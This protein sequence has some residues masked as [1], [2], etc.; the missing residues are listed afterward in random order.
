MSISNVVEGMAIEGAGDISMNDVDIV[1]S[2]TDIVISDSSA[3][4]FLDGTVDDTKVVL[5]PGATGKLDRDRSYIV[6]LDADGTPIADANVVMSSQAAATTSSGTTDATGTTSGLSFSV[7]DIDSSGLTDYSMYY[8]TYKVSTVAEID[9]SW[10]TS[11][12]NV[13]DFRYIQATP[14]NLDDQPIDS[15]T[16]T[17]YDAF[18]LIDQ[19]DVRICGTDSNYVMVSPCAGAA[20]TLSASGSRTYNAVNGVSMVEYGDEEGLHDGTTSMDLTGKAIMIDT[21]TLELRD[22]VTYTFDN[23]VVFDTAYSTQYGTGIAQWLSDYPYGTTLKMHGGEVNGLYPKTA[24]G[25]VVG[26]VIGGLQGA[27]ENALNLDIDGV[28]FNNIIGLATGAGDR[29]SFSSGSLNTYTPST[30]EVKNSFISYYRDLG[31]TPTLFSDADYCLRLGGVDSATISGNTFANCVLSVAFVDEYYD[32]VSTTTHTVLGSNNVVIDDNTFV[33]TVGINVMAWADSDT[34]GLVLSNNEFTCSTCSHVRFQDTT[35]LTSFNPTIDD[36][37]FNGGAY[38]VNTDGVERV[39]INDNTFNNQ[40]DFAIRALGGDFNVEGNEINNPGQYAIYAESLDKPLEIAIRSVAGV[41]SGN[42]VI[43]GQYINWPGDECTRATRP[44]ESPDIFATNAA[45]QE[46]NLELIAGRY[47]NELRVYIT[48]PD[49]SLTIWNPISEVDGEL[50][51]DAGITLD[52]TGLYVFYLLDTWGDGPNGGGFTVLQSDAG[53]WSSN[54][55]LLPAQYWVPYTGG[56][57][58][59]EPTSCAASAG[60]PCGMFTSATFDKAYSNTADSVLIQNLGTSPVSYEIAAGDMAGDGIDYYDN[61][62]VMIE[63]VGTW[64]VSYTH[65]RAHETV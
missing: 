20:G 28:S 58:T 25:D 41:N 44:C 24:N 21:G 36:N 8:N 39:M 23:A 22:G 27:N 55:N 26:L 5:D 37:V 12:T 51:T 62:R 59:T 56:L 47:A 35:G 50:S 3:I 13:G 1:G 60:W 17:N 43:P 46:L 54:T 6:V 32:A 11:T 40:A 9:Y 34:D 2:T 63:P 48:A 19:I 38:G 65:L 7:Y 4:S 57:T 31:I 29:D 52:Q 45:G 30:V 49:G 53:A 61:L 14:S 42:P 64:A 18:S 15:T 16:S 33:G 10:S